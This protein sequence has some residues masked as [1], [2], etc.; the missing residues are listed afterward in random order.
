MLNDINEKPEII[1]KALGVSLSTVYR[2]SSQDKAPKT[3]KMA[4]YWITRWGQSEIDAEM[5]NTAQ[6]YRGLAESLQREI[7]LLKEQIASMG[8][9]GQYGCANDPGPHIKRRF[10][11]DCAEPVRGMARV[12]LATISQDKPTQ[13]VYQAKR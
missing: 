11:L 7:A 4:V 5:W 1:A 12:D 6:A 10:G 8:R 13:Q 9:I 3:A 2:W